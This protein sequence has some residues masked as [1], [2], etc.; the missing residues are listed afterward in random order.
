MNQTIR[1]QREDFLNNKHNFLKGEQ[2][3]KEVVFEYNK[4][5]LEREREIK[6]IQKKAVRENRLY[7]LKR[8]QKANDFKMQKRVK[9]LEEVDKRAQHMKEDRQDYLESR[10]IMVQKLK[11]DLEEMKSGLISPQNIE[12]KYAFLHDDQEFQRMMKE[13][14]KE[15]NPGRILSIRGQCVCKEIRQRV[16]TERW[17]SH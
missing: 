5:I 11:K 8:V 15:A 2:Q 6:E 1:K 9:K 10:K 17:S 4:K 12:S 7:H 14:R 3:F 13:V 16:E